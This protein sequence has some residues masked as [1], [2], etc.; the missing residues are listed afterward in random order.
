MSS[1][2]DEMATSVGSPFIINNQGDRLILQFKGKDYYGIRS[3][4]PR[5]LDPGDSLLAHVDGKSTA[6]IDAL[7]TTFTL[8]HPMNSASSTGETMEAIPLVLFTEEEECQMPSSEM[9]Y[10]CMGSTCTVG[11]YEYYKEAIILLTRLLHARTSPTCI[12][13]FRAHSPQDFVRVSDAWLLSTYRTLVP[14]HPIDSAVESV[15]PPTI[16]D[17]QEAKDLGLDEMEVR[18]WMAIF[19]S[20]PGAVRKVYVADVESARFAA[21]KSQT[22]A[23]CQLGDHDL[24]VSS[25]FEDELET[26]AFAYTDFVV[27]CPPAGYVPVK[28]CRNR[29]FSKGMILSHIK[30]KL[31]VVPKSADMRIDHLEEGDVYSIHTQ[32]AQEHINALRQ[33]GHEVATSSPKEGFSPTHPDTKHSIQVV[34]SVI[35]AKYETCLDLQT[36]KKFVPKVVRWDGSSKVRLSQ[37]T[38]LVFEGRMDGVPKR[39]V[40]EE[41]GDRLFGYLI[42]KT[43]W[44]KIRTKK[45]LFHVKLIVAAD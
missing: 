22:V 43:A 16:P 13:R 36:A 33:M 32:A 7:L 5:I 35:H 24:Y 30:S 12:K 39:V 10:K 2:F 4:G 6:Y 18:M 20:L 38:V 37:G 14:F 3:Q 23:L 17:D 31:P 25:T 42:M 11:R 34:E 27:A 45:S 29:L 19:S 26:R 41:K 21:R 15:E 9:E 1:L 44:V 40:Y 28:M 8:R